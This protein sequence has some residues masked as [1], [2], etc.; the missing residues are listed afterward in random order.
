M[1]LGTEL[2]KPLSLPPRLLFHSQVSLRCVAHTSTGLVLDCSFGFSEG[3]RYQTQMVAQCA[4]FIDAD[5]GFTPEGAHL[6]L[7][8]LERTPAATRQHWFDASRRCSMT[9]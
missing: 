5:S 6:L 4:K 3:S 1:S 2:H 8:L 7:Q 9:L